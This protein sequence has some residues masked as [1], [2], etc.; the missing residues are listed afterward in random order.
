MPANFCLSCGHAL[1]I[2]EISG[3]GRRVCPACGF[4]FWGYYS[5]GV[6]AI[7][8]KGDALLLVRRS[9]EPGKGYWTIP[10]GYCEQNEPIEVTVEREVRE[11]TGIIA[12]AAR[13]VAIRDRPD[14]IH[15]LYVAF[16]MDYVDGD[17]VP[18]GVEVDRADFF[19]REQMASLRIAGLTKWLAE[20]AF[21]CENAGLTADESP[22]VSKT[23][24]SLFRTARASRL[25]VSSR[26]N[27]T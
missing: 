25:D 6:G 10:G 12:H 4:I 7:V 23:V 18:D 19:T 11:E 9:E 24:N 5:M 15:N 2:R 17:P 14:S 20:V 22:F 16:A 1:D 21:S 27:P 26:E 8:L 13:I 3:I